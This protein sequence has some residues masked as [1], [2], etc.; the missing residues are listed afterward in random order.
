MNRT[1]TL[2]QAESELANH[3]P[4]MARLIARHGTCTLDRNPRPPFDALVHALLNQQI[5]IKAAASIEARLR[6]GVGARKHFLPRHFLETE[7][8]TLRGCG[9]SR[10][11]L[12][13]LPMLA[14][15]VQTGRLDFDKLASLDDDAIR[16]EL[17]AYPGIGPWTVEM[18][19]IFGLGR[20]DVFSLGDVGLRRGINTVY[21]HGDKLDDAAIL[22]LSQRWKPWRSV[23]CWYLW[24]AATDDS[25]YWM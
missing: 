3:D 9:L 23:A 24:R 25:G 20:L 18:V 11:K 1:A 16:R 12:R 15:A 7:A 5:S 4:H 17:I 2:R 6:Q 8:D 19:L 10:T 22:K 21:N 14:E 13:W